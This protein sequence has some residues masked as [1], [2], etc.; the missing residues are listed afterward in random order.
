MLVGFY[1]LSDGHHAELRLAGREQANGLLSTCA[2]GDH[3]VVLLGRIHYREDLMA[4]IGLGVEN[5]DS[6][7]D[8]AL[9]LAAYRARG[10]KGLTLLEGNFSLV[11]W[12]E[13]RKILI[14]LRDPMGGYPLYWAQRQGQ[15]ALGTSLL[16]LS[17]WAQADSIDREYL[18]EYLMIPCFGQN[19]PECTNTVYE[20]IQRVR[21]G[22]LVTVPFPSGRV[23]EQVYWHWLDRLDDPGTDKLEAVAQG[24]LSRLRD[25]VRQGMRGTTAAHLSGGMDSTSVYMLALD[26]LQ[27]GQGPLHTISLVYD[28]MRVLAKERPLIEELTR[29]RARLTPHHILGDDLLNF[30]GQIEPPYHDEPWPA[31]STIEV[32]QARVDVASRHGVVSVLTGHGADEM[33]DMGP[34]HIADLLRRGRWLRAWGEACQV[35]RAENASVWSIFYPFGAMNLMPLAIREGPGPWLH[36]G[37]TDW[38]RMDDASIA[39][40]FLPGFARK[41]RLRERGIASL[42]RTFHACRPTVLSVALSKIL[43]RTG[44]LGRWYLS[45]PRGIHV[46]HPFLDPRLLCYC[47]GM[48]ARMS[49]PPR[50]T[51]KPVLADAMRGILPENIRTRPKAGF[52]NEPYFRGMAKHL[53]SLQSLVHLARVEEFELLDKEVLIQCL[54]R[55][56]LGIGNKRIQLDR[57]NLTLSFLKW[58]SMR[59]TWR[60]LPDYF[61]E[62]RTFASDGEALQVAPTQVRACA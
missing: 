43:G 19:E 30:D 39:P 59:E 22:T 12:D 36:N 27:E 61:T 5:L 11:I 14:G 29:N 33:V 52:F 7:D 42:R 31:L 8:A 24:Y 47:L 55:S 25:A 16:G 2:A 40:W 34:Y 62:R 4:R 15:T 23:E 38:D 50:T 32:E 37:Y 13:R 21:P 54:Q 1:T 56:A 58:L 53:Q 46:T 10:S 18:A 41:H 9:V 48:H 17:R 49:P 35:A 20:G 57:V 28:Q 51:P 26:L 6:L 44:D 45:T 3:A 60:R